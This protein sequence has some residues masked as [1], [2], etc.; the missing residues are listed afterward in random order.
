MNVPTN[1]KELWMIPVNTTPCDSQEEAIYVKTMTEL[2]VKQHEVNL[3]TIINKVLNHELSTK[4]NIDLRKYSLIRNQI[5]S[6]MK[7]N[8]ASIASNI[9]KD[10]Y[11]TAKIYLQQSE[12]ITSLVDDFMDASPVFNNEEN[13]N[14]II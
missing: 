3:I 9:A 6:N 5:I 1:L 4:P 2:L 14:I 13:I 11:E 12:Y 10:E 8:N 7:A